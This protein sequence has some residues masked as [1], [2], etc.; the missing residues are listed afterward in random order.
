MY[1][2]LWCEVVYRVI[3]KLISWSLKCWC[4]MWSGMRRITREY[5]PGVLR[6]VFKPICLNSK[7][8]SWSLKYWCM[9]WSGMHR[10]TRE[11][12]P[13]VL[14]FVFKP[15]CLNLKTL[16]WSLRCWC[17]MWSGMRRIKRDIG[18]VFCVLC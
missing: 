18:L 9:M 6:F 14:R 15:I 12:R 17:M 2:R 8:L 13:G 7:K 3:C 5:R 10:I 16:S 11:Y 1:V 4:M